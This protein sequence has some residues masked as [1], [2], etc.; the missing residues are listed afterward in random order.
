LNTSD[1]GFNSGPLPETSV[2]DPYL[3]HAFKTAGT[4][5][6][7]VSDYENLDYDPH[8]GLFD[9]PHDRQGVYDLTVRLL[10]SGD[11]NGDGQ[12]NGGDYTA[13]ADHFLQ[14]VTPGDVRQGDFNGDGIVDGGDYT[15]WADNYLLQAS[16]AA[17]PTISA[18]PGPI[19]K[20]VAP[21]TDDQER[22]V[23][24]ITRNRQKAVLA[25]YAIVD[26]FYARPWRTDQFALGQQLQ[27]RR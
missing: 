17:L 13:W 8:T 9:K 18:A 26:E 5:F 27:W 11:S 25:Y 3:V 4:Y 12:V 19:T 20:Q 15:L 10:P 6:I 2:L 22:T 16:A 24:E 14:T 7:G 21:S 1:D 23:R